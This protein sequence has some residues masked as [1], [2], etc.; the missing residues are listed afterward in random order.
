MLS[1]SNKVICAAFNPVGT[2]LAAG[3]ESGHLI[4]WDYQTRGILRQW[5]VQSNSINAV[6]WSSD[7]RCVVTGGCSGVVVSWN[8]LHGTAAASINL[9]RGSITHLHISEQ[10]LFVSFDTGPGVCISINQD[11]LF[12]ESALETFPVITVT[13]DEKSAR[14]MVVE[15]GY[16][17]RQVVLSYRP[18]NCIF[19]AYEGSITILNQKSPREVIDIV[20]VP[21]SPDITSL[22]VCT[23]QEEDQYLLMIVTK[24]KYLMACLLNKDAIAKA[25][26]GGTHRLQDLKTYLPL[27]KNGRILARLP[28]SGSVFVSEDSSSPECAVLH[29]KYDAGEMVKSPWGCA[30]SS[31]DGKYLYATTC[32]GKRGEENCIFGWQLDGNNH[33]LSMI[34]ESAVKDKTVQ[35]LCHPVPYPMQLLAV[36]GCGDI[37]I[38]TTHFMQRWDKFAPD[39]DDLQENEEYVEKEDE[40]DLVGEECVMNLDQGGAPS[41]SE[42]RGIEAPVNITGRIDDDLKSIYGQDI[43][44]KMLWHLPID[45]K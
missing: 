9:H 29:K 23:P 32:G 28:E 39:W 16:K 41:S 24:D 30:C 31:A 20:R 35:L 27:K 13:G 10:S 25:Q 42:G 19:T 1:A 40:F 18:F 8:I 3:S 22:F 34:L 5:N 15:E 43:P 4:V 33:S 17:S 37:Y 36:N 7:G 38:W 12:E 26:Q 44:E 14:V 45:I 2:L 6:T 11:G 21:G